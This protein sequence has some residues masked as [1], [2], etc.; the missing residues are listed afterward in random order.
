MTGPPEPD[1]TL[2]ARV[3]ASDDRRAF[4]F[5]ANPLGIQADGVLND[6]GNG[7]DF[8]WDAIWSSAGRITPDG[9]EVEIAI[10]FTSLRFPPS[11]GERVWGFQPTR[12]YPRTKR[13]QLSLTPIDRNR[14]CFLCQSARLG[15]IEGVVPGRNIE[16]DPTLTAHRTDDRPDFPSG[17]MERGKTEA[18]AGLSG[19]WGVTPGLSL[20]AAINPDFSQVEADSEQLSAGIRSAKHCADRRSM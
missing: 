2:V 13:H 18:D 11:Q 17:T 9:Y 5:H 4:E 3:L 1:A 8:A 6:V 15:G 7:E 12:S 19:R 20:N 16:L 10:P 14:N